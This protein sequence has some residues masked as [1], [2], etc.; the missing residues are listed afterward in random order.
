MYILHLFI[1]FSFVF[2]NVRIDCI[3]KTE[4]SISLIYCLEI[5]LIITVN[6]CNKVYIFYILYINTFILSIFG[7]NQCFTP[8]IG[9][10]LTFYA[11]SQTTSAKSNPISQLT[12]NGGNGCKYSSDVD[13]IQCSC[14]GFDDFKNPQWDCV[15]NL[16]SDL[17][18]GKVIV[19]CEGCKNSYLQYLVGS[20]GAYY[21]L[22]YKTSGLFDDD[23]MDDDAKNAIGF[24]VAFLFVFTFVLII[25]CITSYRNNQNKYKYNQ[26][27]SNS[28]RFDEIEAVAIN[29]VPSAPPLPSVID[30][31]SVYQQPMRPV[32]QNYNSYKSCQNTHTGD[33]GFTTGMLIGEAMSRNSNNDNFAQDM[34]LINTMNNSSGNN[35]TSGLI[36]GE[37]L[38]SKKHNHGSNH[39]N[40]SSKVKSEHTN[41]ISHGY[42]GTITR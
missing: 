26:V 11:D 20:C 40:K 35:F 8:T 23:N 21:N 29:S 42:G 16:P 32:Y 28:I 36:A 34:L 33:N 12:C 25:I 6:M 17:E 2:F 37:I 22:N 5:Y 41:H 13:T 14:T 39:N 3:K 7:Q 10:T 27:P 30:T 38:G 15:S 4:I 31:Q 18:L 1:N 9:T 19:S 24:F